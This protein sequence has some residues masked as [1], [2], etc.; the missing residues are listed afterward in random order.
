M[1]TQPQAAPTLVEIGGQFELAGYHFECVGYDVDRHGKTVERPGRCLGRVPKQNKRTGHSVAVAPKPTTAY[2]PTA[3]SS[4]PLTPAPR[5]RKAR[6]PR[7]AKPRCSYQR[8]PKRPPP[9]KIVQE[10]W[11]IGQWATLVVV[12][13][14]IVGGLWLWSLGSEQRKW[15]S[16]EAAAR[17][18]QRR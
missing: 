15:D 11:S 7:R 12:I 13:A 6:S 1:S 18:V 5:P 3:Q 17:A 16:I 9:L 14:V 10:P 4:P 2:A 8:F